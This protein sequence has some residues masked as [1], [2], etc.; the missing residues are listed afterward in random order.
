MKKLVLLLLATILIASCRTIKYVEVPTT[1]ET[2]IHK[3]DTV[4]LRDS[5]FVHDSI[6]VF[7]RGD[8][9]YI[10]RTHIAY[11]DRWHYQ[12]KVDT[13][14]QRDTVS[15]VMQVEKP[16]STWQKIKQGIGDFVII[17]VIIGAIVILTVLV[18]KKFH[19]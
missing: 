7:Q 9:V 12:L 14:I 16:P 2:I 15:V 1:H 4:S 6:S 17:I 18:L 5:I 11:K 19:N 13:F 10:D 3:K 8:T